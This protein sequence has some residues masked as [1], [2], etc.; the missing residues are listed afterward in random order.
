MHIRLSALS[1]LNPNTREVIIITRTALATSFLAEMDSKASSLLFIAFLCLISASTAFNITKILAQYPE[2][3]NF[4]DLLSQSGLAQEVNSR[5]TITV[6][7]LD[8]GSIDGLSGRPLDI[9]K[10]IL[11]AHVILDYYDQI[12]LSKLQ[13]ASTIVTTLYQASGVAED[14]QGFL[15]ISRTAEGIK[16]GSAMKGAP[17]AASLVKSVYSQPYNISVLQVSEPIETPGIENMAPPPP[18]GSAAVPKKTPAP[19]PSTK[20]PPAAPPTAKTPAKSPAKSPSKAPAPSKEGPSSPT[21]A[22][23]E[24]PVA[25]DGPVAAVP[26]DSPEA[27][28]VVADEAPAVAPAKAAASGMHV[29]SATVVI[30]LFACIM[31]F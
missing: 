15:N 13:K 8:N 11:S 24:G 2:F 23:A 16:F 4:N 1:A 28:T 20:T 12:K 31:G 7:A 21:E 17:L 22:P 19:A 10:R 29:A 18:P 26:A 27:D 25:A 3:A 30:G 5:Q 9:A 6:L 14:R